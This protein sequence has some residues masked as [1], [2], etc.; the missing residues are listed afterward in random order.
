M[1]LTYLYR[2]LQLITLIKQ[3][4]SVANLWKGVFVNNYNYCCRSNYLLKQWKWH[5]MWCTM[6]ANLILEIYTCRILLINNLLT[7]KVP[8]R[9]ITEALKV[10]N[11]IGIIT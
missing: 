2:H 10:D 4:L 11:S 8:A 1:R 3:L 9:G 6:D 5:N 7:T